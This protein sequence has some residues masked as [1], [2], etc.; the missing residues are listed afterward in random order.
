MIGPFGLELAKY[1]WTIW[2]NLHH[3]IGRKTKRILEPI[4]VFNKAYFRPREGEEPDK[5]RKKRGKKEGKEKR[6][7]LH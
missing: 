7:N 6:E 5:E 1:Y 3:T 4:L 2:S